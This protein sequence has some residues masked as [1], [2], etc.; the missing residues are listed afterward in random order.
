MS[1]LSTV[2]T[3]YYATPKEGFTTTLASTIASG[4]ATVPLNSIS[5]YT[6]G[7][8][9]TMVVE[10]TSVTAKQVFTGVVDTAGVQLTSVK[11]TEGTNQTHN[12]GSTVVDYVTA[13]HMAALVKGLLIHSNQ[14][15]TIKNLAVTTGTLDANLASGWQVGSGTWTYASASTFT[16]PAADAASMSVGTKLWLTQTTSKYWYVAGVSGTTITIAPSTVYTLANAVITAP[17]FSNAATPVGFP[18]WIPYVPTVTVTA[19]TAPTYTGTSTGKYRITN[20]GVDLQFT[21]QNAAGGTA[22]AGAGTLHFSLPVN[23]VAT[24]STGFNVISGPCLAYNGAGLDTGAVFADTATT[25]AIRLRTTAILTGADQ[26]N[27]VRQIYGT[28]VYET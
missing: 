4:A 13:T 3:N 11:W 28:L 18:A 14:D 26:N 1:D 17:F 24:E 6:N 20:R 2:T 5:G 16:V 21:F 8:I 25:C 19:G 9:A 10:P 27:A 22:G 7:A 12:A 23:A 15:G